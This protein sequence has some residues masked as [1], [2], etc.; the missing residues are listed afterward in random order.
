MPNRLARFGD[1]GAAGGGPQF[2]SGPADLAGAAMFPPAPQL[3][4]GGEDVLVV[5]YAVGREGVD[6]ARI[7]PD[8][9]RFG[10]LVD[11]D[12]AVVAVEPGLDAVRR[13]EHR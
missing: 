3:D 8:R 2:R 4:A 9:M 7:R 10:S 13:R 6:T 5:D 1:W 11:R 12:A